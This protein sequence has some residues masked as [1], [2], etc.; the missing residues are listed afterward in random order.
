M[1]AQNQIRVVNP[2]A[3]PARPNPPLNRS[4]PPSSR[5]VPVSATQAHPLVLRAIRTR[6][7]R[8]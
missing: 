8:L 7:F 6:V 2:L 3:H 4:A 1:R 5:T